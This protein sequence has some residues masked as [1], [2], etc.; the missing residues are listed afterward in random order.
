M[1][2]DRLFLVTDAMAHVGCDMQSLPWLES[3]I[4]K[5]GDKLTLDDGSLAGSCLNMA[6]AVKNMYRLL[7]SNEKHAE[8]RSKRMCDV[9]KMASHTP[10]SV[11]NLEKRGRLM[12]DY[13]A[14]FVLLNE[15]LQING[16]WISGLQAANSKMK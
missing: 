15:E 5:M 1:G 11:M 7:S 3:S 9:L 10:A 12:A 13:H 2:A 6:A 14:D 4:N 16:S 8:G